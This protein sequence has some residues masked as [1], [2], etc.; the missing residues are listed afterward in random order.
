MLEVKNL[1]CGYDKRA[2]VVVDDASFK[3]GDLTFLVGP[4]GSGKSTLLKTLA[5]VLSPISGQVLMN[6][7]KLREGLGATSRPAYLP[8]KNQIQFGLTGYDLFDLFHT[9]TS[10]WNSEELQKTLAVKHLLAR[11]IAALSSGEAQRVVLAAVLAHPS[12]AVLLDEPLT[13][14]DWSFSFALTQT[15]ERMRSQGRLFI[16]SSH[17]LNWCIEF[18]QSQS[19]V[20][21]QGRVLLRAP[22]AE[23]LTHAETQRAFQFLSAITDNPLNKKP[24]LALA[25]QDGIRR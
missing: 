5:G 1:L 8:P 7:L 25:A 3:P 21:D 18:Q 23:A 10:K 16:V 9:R 12:Q 22:T 6:S 13:H 17:D 4:N 20:L 14:L 11:P 15:I 2:F 24:L 19:W